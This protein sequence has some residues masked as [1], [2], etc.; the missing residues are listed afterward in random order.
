MITYKGASLD[1]PDSP[2]E[3]R[4]RSASQVGLLDRRSDGEGGAGPGCEAIPYREVLVPMP[5]L[6]AKERWYT[7]N[8]IHTNKFNACTFFPMQALRNAL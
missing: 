1:S 5:P 2:S 8:E 7:N 3:G 6:S 4:A